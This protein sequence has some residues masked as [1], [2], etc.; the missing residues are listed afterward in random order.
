MNNLSEE[1]FR[2]DLTQELIEKYKSMPKGVFS[3]FKA[4]QKGLI[5]LL[6]HK[7]SNEQKLI[8][9]EGQGGEIISNQ[10][11][12]L[13]FLRNNKSLPRYVPQPVENCDKQEIE[14]YSTTLKKW[15][16]NSIEPAEKRREE[17]LQNGTLS[18]SGI[19]AN[20]E[21]ERQKFESDNWNLI[22][23]EVISDEH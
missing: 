1:T 4:G 14:K 9:V 15:L 7:K 13:Q 3:G 22:C 10:N 8:F 6:K 23:W 11:E 2:Q 16:Q 17:D 12:I 19:N 18:L 21:T 20:T 5:A